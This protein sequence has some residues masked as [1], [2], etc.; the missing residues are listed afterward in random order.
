MV[1]QK[2]NEIFFRFFFFRR[3]KI[4]LRKSIIRAF[5]LKELFENYIG[6]LVVSYYEGKHPK[7]HLWPSH[8]RFI[9][10]N[11]NQDDK[12][13]DVGC[14]KSL[15]YNQQLADKVDFMDSVDINETKINY[16]LKDN[17]F[18]NLHFYV[19][20][21]T[22]ELPAKKYDVVIL[23]HILE[24]LFNP[25]D[26]LNKIKK[27]TKKIIVRLPRY[28]NHWM[29]MVKKDLGLYYYKDRDHKQEFTLESAIE[30]IESTGWNIITALNDVDIKIVA[31]INQKK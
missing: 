26:V 21:I 22:K 25:Q 2:L 3:N 28:D 11:I 20:D 13:L 23:S 7:H 15:S 19:L 27:V 14:G 12:V 9:I 5:K 24:H 31:T 1:K 29:N 18:D 17:Q 10:D 6:A 16:C 4:K 30:L 8:Y